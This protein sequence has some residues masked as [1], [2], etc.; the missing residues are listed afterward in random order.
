MTVVSSYSVLLFRCIVYTTY[1]DDNKSLRI[2]FIYTSICESEICSGPN[3][4]VCVCVRVT[5]CILVSCDQGQQ[6]CAD[7]N[8]VCLNEDKRSRVY[9]VRNKVELHL[10][11][12]N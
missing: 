6:R 12:L 8:K 1:E 9:F 7:I 5:V 10:I 11:N 4:G 3:C 2:I